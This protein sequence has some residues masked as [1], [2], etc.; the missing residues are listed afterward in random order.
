MSRRTGGELREK[1]SKCSSGRIG[2]L[3]SGLNQAENHASQCALSATRF[4][5]KASVSRSEFPGNAVTARTSRLALP[6]Y[7]LICGIDLHQIRDFEKGLMGRTIQGSPSL[8]S[9]FPRK[10]L[11]L[12]RSMKHIGLE[13]GNRFFE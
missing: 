2:S 12:L 8:S 7:A 6:N 9:N 11:D 4:P 3:L 1:Q 10:L 13:L 5:H